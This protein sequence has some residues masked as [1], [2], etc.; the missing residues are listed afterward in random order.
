MKD[1]RILIAIPAYNEEKTIKAVVERVRQHMP[2]VDLVVIND[3]SRD[4]T[5]QVLD[6]MGITYIRH[7][8]NLGYGR[9]IQ[10]ALK[11]ACT[12]G[13]DALLTLD[14][15]GQHDAAFLPAII[16]HFNTSGVDL[17]VGSRYVAS[18]LYQGTPLGRQIGMRFFSGL[19]KVLA[20]QQIFDTTSGLKIIRSTTFNDL[21]KWHFVD[22][23]AE[24]IVYL[25]HLGY[26]IEEFPIV[27]KEREHGQSMYSL[28][29][30]LTYPIQT[31]L[32]I[33]LG[34]IEAELVR[35]SRV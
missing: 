4:K 32:M 35:R 9:A 5:L 22:F 12:Y 29:S 19:T 26:R 25:L 33:L 23:H 8:C 7:A 14:A 2:G 34:V 30:H 24:A 11:Y 28:L 1:Q 21:V 10:T 17:L 31:L 16:Q 15:D 3:G 6:E 13:Y 20:K 18:R 27:V